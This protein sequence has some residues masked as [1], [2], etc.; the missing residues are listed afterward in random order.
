M[1]TNRNLKRSR[2]QK[3]KKKKQMVRH[4][5]S[6]RG[7]SSADGDMHLTVSK[8]GAMRVDVPEDH[9]PE[10]LN[11]A[12][13]AIKTGQIDEA[14]ALLNDDNIEIVRQ[15]VEK[16]PSRP[17]VMYILA[18]NLFGI[19]QYDASAEWYQ[20]IL[21]R[22]PHWAV[23]NELANIKEKEGKRAEAMENRIK[24]LEANPDSG[25][26]LNNHAMDMCRIGETQ[27]GIELLRK[28]LEKLPDYPV[29][30][31]NL[32]F[33]MHY[34]PHVDR[35][36]L[37]DEHKRWARM[38]A[39]TTLARTSHDNVPDPNRRLRVGYISPDFCIHSVAFFFEILLD[40]HN[41]QAVETYGYSNN[42]IPDE[43]TKRLESKFDHFRNIYGVSDEAVVDMIIKDKIDILVDL[44]G[45]TGDNRLPVLGYKPAP[46]Q[47]T[48]LG[49]PN[50]T[51]TEQVDY[52]L[53][54]ELADP[55]ESRQFYTEELVYLPDGFL[56]YRPPDYAPPVVPLPHLTITAR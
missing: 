43:G 44:A 46:I 34:M 54:D 13:K 27:R 15:M 39:P 12:D 48:Y 33:F 21:E 35:Q 20:K 56:C 30:H 4:S 16:D 3:K 1:N 7:I 36:L 49:Y 38:Q 14:R 55:P 24:A 10:F 50:T 17:G 26:V 52:R 23:Y 42:R 53:T 18:M 8:N 6:S 25:V 37:F 45:H 5:S 11:K 32:V 40:E 22:K 31:S 19:G 28:A 9:L 51:G 2:R 47:V 29:V 41:R